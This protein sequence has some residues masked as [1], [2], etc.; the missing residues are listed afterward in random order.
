MIEFDKNT[1][2][3]PITP[4]FIYLSESLN[5]RFQEGSSAPK[6]LEFGILKIEIFSF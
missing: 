5:L 2:P 3:A 6:N 4:Y 1:P